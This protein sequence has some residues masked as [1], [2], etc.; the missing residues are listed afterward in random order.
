MKASRYLPLIG[1]VAVGFV[2]VAFAVVGETP[3][4][5]D[6]ALKVAAFYR[7]NDSAVSASGVLLMAAAASFLGWAIQVRGLL[8]SAER[9]AATRT[10]LGLVGSV[11]FGAGL[12]VFAGL[13]LALGDIPERLTP[14]S[15]Q[16]LHVLSEDM[17]PMLAVGV[18]FVL[19]GYGLA[20]VATRA[21]PAWL[22]WVA[23][24][25]AIAVLTPAWFVPFVALGIVIVVSSVL[26]VMERGEATVGVP[27]TPAPAA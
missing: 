12:T 10:T 26:M 5:K 13:N 22:G 23:I 9:G 15:I 18:L 17:F 1:L 16:T 6:S 21:L 11:F 7:E 20:I 2:V 4:N 27:R 24:V 8:F 3:D 14:S 19:L 25:G